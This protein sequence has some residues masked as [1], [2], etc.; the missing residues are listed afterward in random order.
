MRLKAKLKRHKL[1]PKVL[2]NLK[3][4]ELSLRA[5]H[6]KEAKETHEVDENGHSVAFKAYEINFSHK[7]YKPYLQVSFLENKTKY[8]KMFKNLAS[9]SQKNPKKNIDK[10]GHE[11]VQDIRG[12]IKRFQLSPVGTTIGRI[13][14]AVVFVH[15]KKH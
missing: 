4:L 14:G 5:G 1:N 11:M 3:S 12:T 9:N 15:S 10:I 8:K 7:G 13:Y 6:P 2:E